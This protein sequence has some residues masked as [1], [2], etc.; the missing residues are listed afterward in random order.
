[1]STSRNCWPVLAQKAQGRAD[2]CRQVVNQAWSGVQKAHNHWVSVQRMV[3]EYTQRYN[4]AQRNSHTINDSLN[5]REFLGQLQTLAVKAEQDMLQA[6]ISHQRAQQALAK[7]EHEVRKMNKLCELEVARAEQR[8][9]RQ[10]QSQM[11]E[12]AVM[13]H[14]WRHA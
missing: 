4:Q 8:E 11:D 13:R 14:H 6:K 2:E 12:L 9:K 10:E 1:M 7:A 3:A 5:F